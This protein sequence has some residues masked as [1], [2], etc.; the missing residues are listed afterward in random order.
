MNIYRIG[1]SASEA[2]GVHYKSILSAI[3]NIIIE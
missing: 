1:L 3:N 2:S